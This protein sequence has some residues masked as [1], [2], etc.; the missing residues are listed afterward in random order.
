MFKMPNQF[1]ETYLFDDKRLQQIKKNFYSYL[2]QEANSLGLITRVF[3][4]A[5]PAA[6]PLAVT[7]L[8]MIKQLVDKQENINLLPAGFDIDVFYTNPKALINCSGREKIFCLME[9]YRSLNQTI[10]LQKEYNRLEKQ[11]KKEPQNDLLR[12]KITNLVREELDPETK[13][14]DRFYI[15]NQAEFNKKYPKDI[16]RKTDSYL[17]QENN[18]LGDDYSAQSCLDQLRKGGC[19]KIDYYVAA[20]EK[21]HTQHGRLDETALKAEI[22]KDLQKTNIQLGDAERLN[23]LADVFENHK[24]EK[25][26]LFVEQGHEAITV[27]ALS[28]AIRGIQNPSAQDYVDALRKGDFLTFAGFSRYIV[29][30]Y[31]LYLPEGESLAADA[32]IPLSCLELSKT[33]FAEADYKLVIDGIKSLSLY[34]SLGG[35]EYEYALSSNQAASKEYLSDPDFYKFTSINNREDFTAFLTACKSELD[36]EH[37]EQKKLSNQRLNELDLQWEQKWEKENKEREKEKNIFHLQYVKSLY[38]V[39]SSQFMRNMLFLIPSDDDGTIDRLVSRG[40]K[41]EFKKRLFDYQIKHA[42]QVQ[43][44]QENVYLG[45][46]IQKEKVKHKYEFERTL[47]SKLPEGQDRK[48]FVEKSALQKAKEDYQPDR[49]KLKNEVAKKLILHI[50]SLIESIQDWRVG[51]LGIGGVFNPELGR[52]L[53]R[54][55]AEIYDFCK[56]MSDAEKFEEKY[57]SSAAKLY[58]AIEEVGAKASQSHAW[59]FSR[60]KQTQAFY[61]QFKAG[62]EERK[63]LK[64]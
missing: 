55:V 58:Q 3:Q 42:Y 17:K 46:D 56:L 51:R 45:Q 52:K 37:K 50:K 22:L 48:Q 13:F 49:K 38:G 11:L 44:W 57:K 60:S 14:L 34:P 40:E 32:L 7:T 9:I 43:K 19:F 15:P 12:Q 18:F 59:F 21:K 53:P 24:N 28:S 61:D 10:L 8:D 27:P 2:L 6:D 25:G 35:G 5:F 39:C 16:V 33:D 36:D 63:T 26:T 64:K 41:E 30:K 23:V 31:T 4:E 62:A 1:E 20:K 47:P 29:E 54:H